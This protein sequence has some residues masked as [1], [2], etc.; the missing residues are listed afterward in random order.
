MKDLGARPSG[1]ILAGIAKL[2]FIAAFFAAF[3]PQPAAKAAPLSEIRRIRVSADGSDFKYWTKDS[4]ALK[5]LIAYVKDVTDKKSRNYIP[6][7]DRIAVY[8]MDGTLV[9]ERT[10][11]YNTYVAWHARLSDPSFT[12]TKEQLDFE[13]KFLKAA[14]TFSFTPEESQRQT[15]DMAKDYA[16]M[17]EEE[18][19]DYIGKVLAK[20][21]VW[22]M[23]N[24]TYAESF[25]LPMVEVVKYL[26]ANGFKNFVVSAAERRLVRALCAGADLIPAECVIGTDPCFKAEGQGDRS[27]K[28]Y[29]IA[30][31][32][33]LIYDGRIKEKLLRTNKVAAIATEIGKRPV[34]AFGNSTGDLAMFN[35][36]SGNKKYRAL[37]FS[38]LCDDA[39]REYGNLKR[40]DKMRDMCL[41]NGWVP[42]SM[43]HDFATI[44][45]KNVKKKP[46]EQ[47]K[48]AA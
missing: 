8:D 25:F 13:E 4:E 6:E 16:G 45:G 18:Y 26:E 48:E 36:T 28:G 37:S 33:K 3:L 22:G 2:L 23:K 30:Q 38:L 11:Y 42:V 14:A 24:M 12:A 19:Q 1:R 17:T 27:G 46:V 21:P 41:E 35:Y 32:E 5:K 20:T 29:V 9:G 44:Y 10:P 15:E 47:A 39:V 40:A 7:K 43:A 31:D 34:L